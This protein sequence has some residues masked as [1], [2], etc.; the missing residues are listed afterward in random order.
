MTQAAQTI[1]RARTIQIRASDDEYDRYAKA[2]KADGEHTMSEW[3]R[4]TLD[5]RAAVLD[6]KKATK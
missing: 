4:K 6:R 5:K 2:T 3:I 1:R